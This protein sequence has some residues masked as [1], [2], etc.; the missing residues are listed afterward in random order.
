MG[1]GDSTAA[2]SRD[3]L[4]KDFKGPWRVLQLG[5]NR[6]VNVAR[7]VAWQ[8]AK[9]S[10]IQCLDSDDFL[11]NTKIST[12]IAACAEASPDVGVAY[13]SFQPVFV[14][15]KKIIPAGPTQSAPYL[16]SKPPIMFL[17]GG[18]YLMHTT[19]LI[20][21]SV[22]DSVGGFDETLRCYEEIELIVRIAHAG[23]RFLYVP[24]DEPSY[25]WRWYDQPR[26]GGTEARYNLAVS[27]LSWMEV[28]MRATKGQPLKN[29]PIS[30]EDRKSIGRA[31]TNYA[32]RL[33]AR[34]QD[35]FREF[36]AKVRVLEPKFNPTNPW[37]L[38][39]LSHLIGYEN[40]EAVAQVARRPRKLFRASFRKA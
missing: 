12:Q 13:S 16:G 1:R 34:D 21:R 29:L 2:L 6:G 9:G 37:Y 36:I 20:R 26:E 3:K 11:S 40:A 14:D 4:Q 7:N 15:D 27:A 8:A 30:S 5:S 28:A 17:V 24:T 19:C 32:R 38:A 10:W 25:L 35:A 33:Y 23:W 18:S 31:F 39:I 22:L